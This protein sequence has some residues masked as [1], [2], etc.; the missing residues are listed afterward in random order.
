MVVP[1]VH[2]VCLVTLAVR[3]KLWLVRNEG[4]GKLHAGAPLV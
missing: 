3:L 2:S 4:L 1:Y